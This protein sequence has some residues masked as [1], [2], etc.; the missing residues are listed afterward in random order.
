MNKSLSELVNLDRA[1]YPAVDV[2][3]TLGA[4]LAANA[5]VVLKGLFLQKG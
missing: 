5:T 4:A 2:A 1:K 3:L